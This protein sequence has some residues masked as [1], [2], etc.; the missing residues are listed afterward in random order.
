VTATDGLKPETFKAFSAI[1]LQVV[2][3]VAVAGARLLGKRLRLH[4]LLDGFT[5]RLEDVEQVPAHVLAAQQLMA[6]GEP[7]HSKV[8]FPEEKEQRS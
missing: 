2:F 6:L 7:Q 1:S 3:T 4:T 5:A 8:L